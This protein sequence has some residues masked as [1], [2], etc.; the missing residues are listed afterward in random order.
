[1]FGANLMAGSNV[2]VQRYS[3]SSLYV[4]TGMCAFPIVVSGSSNITDHLFFNDDGK[5]VRILVTVD[6]A[7]ITSSANGKSLTAKGSG[8]IEYELNPDRTIS[9]HTFGINLL[10]TI[11][12]YGSVI[13]DTGSAA[14][15]FDPRL[16]ELFHAGPASYD[17][18]AFCAAL[19]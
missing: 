6:H 12:H 13:L 14:F 17:L 15:L 7:D 18:E 4:E 19:S 10:L 5:L 3:E 1:V 2:E 8:G 11:P 9:V 16:H